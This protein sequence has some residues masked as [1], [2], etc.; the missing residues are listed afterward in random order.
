M[1]DAFRDL[2]AHDRLSIWRILFYPRS[3]QMTARFIVST[4]ITA[5][6]DSACLSIHMLEVDPRGHGYPLRQASRIVSSS[7]RVNAPSSYVMLFAISLPRAERR[8]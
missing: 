6:I 5:P 4:S 8:R 1:A 3:R 2:T 7:R